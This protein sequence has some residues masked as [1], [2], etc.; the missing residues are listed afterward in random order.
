MLE[1]FVRFKPQ[2]VILDVNLPCF[3]GF[4]WCGKIRELSNVPVI[5][6]SSRDSN[7]EG[8]LLYDGHKLELTRNELKIM[9][10]LLN[11][12]GRVVSRENIMQLLW[13]DDQFVNDNTL[14]VNINRL[15]SRLSEIGLE[16]MIS[17]MTDLVLLTSNELRRSMAD[18]AYL[19]V[20]F[21]VIAL[22]L[23]IINH[24]KR[25]YHQVGA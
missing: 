14:T 21:A 13:D 3:D 6:L 10:L 12:K 11:R 17:T 1:D 4:Y 16:D 20:L 18:T 9:A 25:L 2:L 19:N 23:F 7:G 5:F 24:L 22:V 8:T 15:R